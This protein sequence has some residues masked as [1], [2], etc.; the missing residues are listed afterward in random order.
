MIVAVWTVTLAGPGSAAVPTNIPPVG[1]LLPI[2]SGE[3][4]PKALPK[5][6]PAPIAM[7]LSGKVEALNG[8][9]LPAL[10]EIDLDVDRNVS[11]DARGL[12]VCWFSV[13]S[14]PMSERCR[15]SLVGTG[16]METQVEFPEQ[17]P[18]DLKSKLLVYNG[19]V[20]GGTTTIYAHAY[21]AS[22]INDA[23]VMKIKVSKEHKGRFGTK[24]T[25]A[26]PKIAGGFGSTKEFSLTIHREFAYKGKRR[27]YLLGKCPDGHLNAHAMS[28]F[29]DGS[30]QAD[31]FVRACTPTARTLSYNPPP[32]A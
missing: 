24:W 17:K 18:I 22:P 7:G 25:F 6:E 5:Y 29:S 3:F 23:I 26:I 13:E 21:L 16:A 14:P 4:S 1:N 19:G 32:R 12:P 31:Q 15:S 20:N 30:A 10:K 2:I 9:R 11:I 8:A 27:S 28:V